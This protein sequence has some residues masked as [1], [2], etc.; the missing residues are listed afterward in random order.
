[1]GSIPPE[2]TTIHWTTTSFAIVSFSC[3]LLFAF[4]FRPNVTGCTS[5]KRGPTDPAR[6]PGLHC[7][8]PGPGQRTG[9]PPSRRGRS[10]LV[11]LLLLVLVVVLLPTSGGYRVLR[12]VEVH[13]EPGLISLLRGTL[14]CFHGGV[15]IESTHPPTYAPTP[16]TK[17]VPEFF[18]ETDGDPARRSNSGCAGHGEQLVSVADHLRFLQPGQQVRARQEQRE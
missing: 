15:L 16:S 7:A 13:P 10:P 12:G 8:L 4:S 11:V 6:P 9:F 2:R 1:M 17:A 18:A 5:D 3:I 14:A